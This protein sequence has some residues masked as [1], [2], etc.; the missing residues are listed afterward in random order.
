MNTGNYKS[1]A[2]ENQENVYSKKKKRDLKVLEG[3]EE[4][5]KRNEKM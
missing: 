2:K 5:N 3:M 4:A 1:K